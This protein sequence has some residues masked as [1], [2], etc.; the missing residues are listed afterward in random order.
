[1]ENNNDSNKL[2]NIDWEILTKDEEKVILSFCNLLIDNKSINIELDKNEILNKNVVHNLEIVLSVSSL[3]HLFNFK[4][5][6]PLGV[7][8][9]KS[10]Y[11]NT[12]FRKWDTNFH[13]FMKTIS[14]TN[15]WKSLDRNEILKLVNMFLDWANKNSL[16]YFNTILPLQKKITN[17]LK[18]KLNALEDLMNFLLKQDDYQWDFYVLKNKSYGAD[19]L[20]SFKRNNDSSNEINVIYLCFW[21]EEQDFLFHDSETLSLNI[22]SIQNKIDPK[23]FNKRISNSNKCSISKISSIALNKREQK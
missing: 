11:S 15:S 3:P 18:Y 21:Q 16:Y 1:M 14:I 19:F 6:A 23:E 20:I 17:F 22:T 9:Y 2:L 13:K 5:F 12:M 7:N 8:P 4:R 10:S